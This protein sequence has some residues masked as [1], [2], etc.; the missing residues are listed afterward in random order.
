MKSSREG[1]IALNKK[2]AEIRSRFRRD[3]KDPGFI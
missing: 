1:A 3:P 2:K